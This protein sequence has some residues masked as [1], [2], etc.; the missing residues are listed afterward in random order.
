MS[1]PFIGEIRMFAGNF[2]PRGWAFCDGAIQEIRNNPALFSILGTIYGGDGR[3]TFGLPDLQ[4][5]APMHYG[6]G[7]GLS[8]RRLGEKDGVSEVTLTLNQM[9]A[10]RHPLVAIDAPPQFANPD[11]NSLAQGMEGALPYA[12]ESPSVNM[13][14]SEYGTAGD[15]QNEPH[16]NLQPL[17]VVHFIIALEGFFPS[18]S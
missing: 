6:A 15:S 12:A 14:E 7:P 1:E 11:G 13:M 9:A 2:A 18:R 5:R 4:G 17:Q 8:E 3:T 10:H 16:L